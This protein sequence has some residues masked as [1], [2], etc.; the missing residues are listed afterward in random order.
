MGTALTIKDTIIELKNKKRA[1]FKCSRSSLSTLRKA[2][3]ANDVRRQKDKSSWK[4]DGGVDEDGEDDDDF[5]DVKD[6]EDG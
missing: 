6:E 5:E 4:H 3:G 2:P 1:P